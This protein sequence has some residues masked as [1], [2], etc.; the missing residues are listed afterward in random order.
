VEDQRG[1]VGIAEAAVRLRISKDAVRRRVQRG[2]LTA[3]KS[4]DDRW[5]VI[6]PDDETAGPGTEQR[7]GTRDTTSAARWDDDFATVIATFREQLEVKDRQ[8]AE[9]DKQISELHILLQTSQQNEQRLLSATVP[10]AVE[11]RPGAPDDKSPISSEK[12]SPGASGDAEA[13]SARRRGWLARLF[14]VE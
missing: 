10:E 9:K 2:S 13:P 4:S 3:Y 12:S 11:S 14:G 1:G 5:L 7:G 6:I 8:L